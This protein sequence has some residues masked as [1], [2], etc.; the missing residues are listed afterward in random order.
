MIAKATEECNELKE[1]A[2]QYAISVTEGARNFVASSLKGYQD[3]AV[4]N[5]N[6]INSVN[7]QFQSEYAAQVQ[8]L[9]ID[10]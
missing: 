9:G 10:R 7:T 3:I 4:N 2:R 6:Q 5:L 1:N 8:V